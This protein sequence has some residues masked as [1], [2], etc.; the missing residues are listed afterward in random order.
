MIRGDPGRRHA[1]V[2]DPLKKR[3]F[4]LVGCCVMLSRF[5]SDFAYPLWYYI[6]VPFSTVEQSERYSAPPAYDVPSRATL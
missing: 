5:V 3:R 1:V 6:G 4:H 2:A